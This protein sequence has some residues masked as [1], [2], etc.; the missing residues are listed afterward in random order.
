MTRPYRK[1]PDIEVRNARAEKT[2]L[3]FL[4]QCPE[5]LSRFKLTE[6]SRGTIE[7]LEAEGYAVRYQ[8][9][10]LGFERVRITEAGRMF[11]IPGSIA[12]RVEANP[13]SQRVAGKEPA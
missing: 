9:D 8:M 10:G 5:G 13:E 6:W 3:Q 4:N 1:R 7:R 2:I 11:L 12:V